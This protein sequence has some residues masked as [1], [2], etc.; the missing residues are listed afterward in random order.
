M[1]YGS[2]LPFGPPKSEKYQDVLR[3]PD[4][5][6]VDIGFSAVLKSENKTIKGLESEI[7]KDFQSFNIY[8]DLIVDTDIKFNTKETQNVIGV[9][10][11]NDPE[12][13]DEYIIIGAHYDHLGYG[14]HKSGSRRPHINEVHNGA[15]D[16]ASGVSIVIELAKSFKKI[17]NKRSVIF[18][19]FG[20]EEMGLIGSKFFVNSSLIENKNI[21]T[22]INFDM[23]GKLKPEKILPNKNWYKKL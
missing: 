13:K 23:V 3:I 21:Q 8:K 17:N 11:G 20:A 10:F 4:Y 14:G 1:I 7:S 2:G 22:M 9:K 6:R 15:D 12:L 16:N 18:I 5:R 19:A